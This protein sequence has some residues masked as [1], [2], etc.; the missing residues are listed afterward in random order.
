[1]YFSLSLGLD[2]SGFLGSPSDCQSGNQRVCVQE[3]LTRRSKKLRKELRAQE[4]EK[5]QGAQ[6]ER[7]TRSGEAGLERLY[8]AG[9]L[10]DP[11]SP[12]QP[13]QLEDM[14][15]ESLRVQAIFRAMEWCSRLVVDLQRMAKDM[16]A[17]MLKEYLTQITATDPGL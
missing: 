16:D 6:E 11:T 4:E 9:C 3:R 14:P 12:Q 15:T 7:G 10:Q 8:R 5:L 2:P 1:M 17:G 13:G